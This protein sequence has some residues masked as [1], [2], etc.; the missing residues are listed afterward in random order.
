MA[1]TYLDYLRDAAGYKRSLNN[2]LSTSNSKDIIY[3][4][5]KYLYA[6]KSA[7]KL[8]PTASLPGSGKLLADEIRDELVNHQ[9]HLNAA[10]NQNK[11]ATGNTKPSIPKEVGLKMRRLSTSISQANFATGGLSYKKNI[12]KNSAS[13]AGSVLIK[14]PIVTS[15]KVIS[16]V[17]P[18]AVT[19][20]LLPALLLER[21]IL[22]ISAID[23]TV[24]VN[25]KNKNDYTA[26]NS[27]GNELKKGI[28]QIANTIEKNTRSI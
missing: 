20:I 25:E 2:A 6:L 21:G 3:Y 9:I 19:I 24:G 26:I 27:L 4:R 17:G 18:L 1:K 14:A 11:K 13:L 16:K 15:A 12:I 7:H 8:N 22:E 5:G 10:I 23:G 28:K